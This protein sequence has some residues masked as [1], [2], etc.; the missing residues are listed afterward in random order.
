M[1][2]Q[3]EYRDEKGY[4]I[5]REEFQRI[6]QETLSHPDD[7][8]R[9]PYGRI[10]FWS[11]SQNTIVIYDPNDV[12]GGTAYRPDPN[13][14]VTRGYFDDMKAWDLMTGRDETMKIS[15]HL[16]ALEADSVVL[17]LSWGGFANIGKALNEVCLGYRVKDFSTKMGAE[18]DKVKQILLA[19]N[20]VRDHMVASDFDYVSVRLSRWEL[21]A[22]IG[23][24]QEVC[25][26]LGFEFYA[27]MGVEVGEL[28]QMT[29][30]LVPIYDEMC[31]RQA[32]EGSPPSAEQAVLL[33]AEKYF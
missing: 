2:P 7:A 18:R 4:P 13:P 5:S 16:K 15:G 23:A 30:E 6:I 27:R 20:P 29:A 21:R 12:D 25:S 11:E 8:Y 22:I 9:C 19:G 10:K 1:E 17:T 33:R 24:L 26:E 28:A 32:L 31:R 3:G 14:K